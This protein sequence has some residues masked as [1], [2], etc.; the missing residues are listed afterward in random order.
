[1]LFAVSMSVCV[2]MCLCS[3]AWQFSDNLREI[4]RNR[5]NLKSIRNIFKMYLYIWPIYNLELTE[6]RA[7]SWK[8][9][10]DSR[11]VF[12]AVASCR[13]TWCSTDKSILLHY[14][15]PFP[16]RFL[17]SLAISMLPLLGLSVHKQTHEPVVPIQCRIELPIVTTTIWAVRICTI[18]GINWISRTLR[19]S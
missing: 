16:N 2:A 5:F 17:L 7:L 8:Q 11:N 13:S 14:P 4:C 10:T 3:N 19:M 15:L 9:L 18:Y 6:L 12:V 1:M